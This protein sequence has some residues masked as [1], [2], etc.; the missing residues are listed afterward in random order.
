[1]N[2]DLELNTVLHTLG[3]LFCILA[4]ITDNKDVCNLGNHK[5]CS[6]V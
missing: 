5:L 6:I 2:V 3:E 1:M 4:I